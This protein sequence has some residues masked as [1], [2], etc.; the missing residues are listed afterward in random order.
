M[1]KKRWFLI[2]LAFFFL[3]GTNPVGASTPDSPAANQP[4]DIKLFTNGLTNIKNLSTA[5]VGDPQIPILS[6]SLDAPGDHYI[7]YA[8][9]ATTATLG[10]C[11]PDNTWHCVKYWFGNLVPGTVSPINVSQKADNH[12]LL[13]WAFQTVDMIRSAAIELTPDM[14]YYTYTQG[15]LLKLSK[16]GSELVGTPTLGY[17]GG[18][19]Q[20]AATIRDNTDL[21]GYKL[22]NMS[23]TVIANTSCL[24]SGVYY[25]CYM[26]DQSNGLDSM[27]AASLQTALDGSPGIAYTK[28]GNLMFAYFHQ[29]SS[30]VPSNCGLNGNTW[31]CISILEKAASSVMGNDLKHAAGLTGDNRA[32]AFTFG[33]TSAGKYLMHATFVGSGGNCGTDLNYLGNSVDMWKCNLVVFLG[34]TDRSFSIAIDPLGYS[35]IAYEYATADLAPVGLYL[36]F[37]KARAGLTGSDWLE[38]RID[39]APTDTVITGALAALGLNSE[40]L[41][42]IGYLQ[43]EDYELPDLKFAWQQFAWQQFKTHL[44]LIIR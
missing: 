34:V 36:G 12:I 11:G 10:N 31:R 13:Q 23:Y 16:F 8:H 41:G 42:F 5:F 3:A 44:P 6:Y 29:P 14:N 33:N 24:E 30:Q 43:K 7:Y 32:I 22:V 26:V 20:M 27:G 18:R 25:E 17:W 35:V 9:P 28:N 19:L 39:F 2:I 40:G 38:Q 1:N 21:Y 4:W 37:P 15:D